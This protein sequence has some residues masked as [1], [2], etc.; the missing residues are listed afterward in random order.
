MA[1]EETTKKT[2]HER[3]EYNVAKEIQPRWT[4]NRQ[5]ERYLRQQISKCNDKFWL[6][7]VFED[8]INKKIG[9]SGKFVGR[10]ER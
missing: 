6:N 3:W 8:L 4:T 10:I 5:I 2:I 1:M 9:S 7:Y